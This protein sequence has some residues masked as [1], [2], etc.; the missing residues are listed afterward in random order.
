M[1]TGALLACLNSISS[2]VAAQSLTSM[3]AGPR[4]GR[5]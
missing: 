3:S 5:G 1:A 4:Q 2:L